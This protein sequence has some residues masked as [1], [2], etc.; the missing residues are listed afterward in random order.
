MKFFGAGSYHMTLA[1]EHGMVQVQSMNSVRLCKVKV[2][3]K[4]GWNMIGLGNHLSH[5]L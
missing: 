5:M 2:V 3:G 4:P 1:L